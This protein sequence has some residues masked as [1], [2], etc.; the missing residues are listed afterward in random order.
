PRRPDG[1]VRPR[2]AAR[3][4]R[5][6]GGRTRRLRLAP[7]RF[8]GG[9]VGRRTGAGQ[10]RRRRG[11]VL[12]ARPTASRGVTMAG[13]FDQRVLAPDPDELA[14]WLARAYGST[15]TDPTGSA[16]L[17]EFRAF[18]AGAAVAAEGSRRWEWDPRPV[19]FRTTAGNEVQV[20]GCAWWTD[21]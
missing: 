18:A 5:R 7:R 3:L 12:A 16:A 8:H 13:D 17:P 19:G 15:G 14:A 21:A 1:V 9:A 6:L 11:A 10:R 20:V 4:G 2:R